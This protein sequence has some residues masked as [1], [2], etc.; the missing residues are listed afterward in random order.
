MDLLK[1]IFAMM[2]MALLSTTL[3]AKATSYGVLAPGTKIVA[4][5]L[6]KNEFFII[7]KNDVI[8]VKKL[9]KNLQPAPSMPLALHQQKAFKTKIFVTH[10]VNLAAKQAPRQ[11]THKSLLSLI[12]VAGKKNTFTLKLAL[13]KKDLKKNHV[14]FAKKQFKLKVKLASSSHK[15]TKAV[16]A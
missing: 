11:L 10:K 4:G 5:D 2:I 15:K 8:P 16:L 7:S 3:Y 6:T 9:E 12:P 1:L 14:R 13:P